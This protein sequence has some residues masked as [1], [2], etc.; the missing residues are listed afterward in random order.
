[1]L[2]IPQAV[3]V[4]VKI[5]SLLQPLTVM[6][7]AEQL[8]GTDPQLLDADTEPPKVCML[9][10]DGNVEGLQP[11]SKVLLQLKKVGVG[12]DVAETVNVA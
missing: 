3:A 10:Q 5:C 9:E 7:P 12:I 8:T 4:K 2:V 6:V 11:R 1:V